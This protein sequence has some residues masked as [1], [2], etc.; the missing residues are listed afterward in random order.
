MMFSTS[1]PTYP[2]SVSVV[3][4]TIANGTSR[5]LASV[6]AI[7]VLPVP[8]G[9]IS[10]MLDFCSSTSLLRSR[11]MWTRLQWLYTATASFFL[12]AFL[13]DHVL[14]QEFLHF[15][16]LRDSVEAPGRRLDL[17]VFQNRV[18]NRDALV[19]DV[20]SGVIARGRDELPDYVLA[21]MAKR[22]A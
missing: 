13:P 6:C 19:A 3:A 16:R 8:V 18:A 4:S 15:Q 14:V 17:I 5:I 10:R 9:P 7:N 1:S 12:V 11:F 22:T 20:G 2:A 21:L